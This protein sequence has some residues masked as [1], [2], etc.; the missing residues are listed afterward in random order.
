[1]RVIRRPDLET[2]ARPENLFQGKVDTVS[3]DTKALK[4]VKDA[5]KNSPRLIG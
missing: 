5:R 3:T 4:S 2:V 1:M